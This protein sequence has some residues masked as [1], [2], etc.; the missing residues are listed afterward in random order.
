MVVRVL[1][2]CFLVAGISFSPGYCSDPSEEKSLHIF[3]KLPRDFVDYIYNLPGVMTAAY[4][5]NKGT[6]KYLLKNPKRKSGRI[7]WLKVPSYILRL[8]DYFRQN[9][10][11]LDCGG[12]LIQLVRFKF[13]NLKHLSGVVCKQ[14]ISHLRDINS[15]NSKFLCIYD[16][17]MPGYVPFDAY[18]ERP[19]HFF[20]WGLDGVKALETLEVELGCQQN[21]KNFIEKLNELT[22]LRSLVVRTYFWDE[23]FLELKN[24][25]AIDVNIS[26]LAPDEQVSSIEA[27]DFNTNATDGRDKKLSVLEQLSDYRGLRLLSLDGILL[28]SKRL[29]LICNNKS[30][31]S[32]EFGGFYYNSGTPSG[33]RLPVMDNIQLLQLNC[34]FRIVKNDADLRNS[35]EVFCL[36]NDFAKWQNLRNVTLVETKINAEDFEFLQHLSQLESLTLKSAK[37]FRPDDC[38]TNAFTPLQHLT[39]LQSLELTRQEPYNQALN[40]QHNTMLKTLKIHKCD[41]SKLSLGN[42]V[43]TDVYLVQEEQ[44]DGF[45]RILELP[46]LRHLTIHPDGIVGYKPVYSRLKTLRLVPVPHECKSYVELLRNYTNLQHVFIG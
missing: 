18:F 43:L 23:I 5:I 35:G 42:S 38:Q 16:A 10:A 7:L 41:V 32:L 20:L 30:L 24:L 33:V 12:E 39:R 40:L 2:L 15:L 28:S 21:I 19:R 25:K 27:G 11:A 3:H 9:L 45:E 31:R 1:V 36:Q 46:A 17:F 34:Q 29:E 8:N 22:K 6:R 4:P 26:F 44:P 13:P 37:L 14:K